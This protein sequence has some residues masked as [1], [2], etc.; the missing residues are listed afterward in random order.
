LEK[1]SPKMTVSGFELQ[2]TL[3]GN[4][5]TIRPLRPD[6]LEALFAVASDPLIWEQ[7]PAKTRCQRPGFEE[8]FRKGLE[9]G[10]AFLF[11]EAGTGEVI[12]SSRYCNLAPE[13]SEVEIGF[14]FLARRCWGGSFNREIKRLMIDH[15]FRFVD[16]VVFL[17]G[18]ENRRSRI[19]I[20]RIGAKLETATGLT[21][22]AS[23]GPHV[24]YRLRK[25]EQPWAQPDADR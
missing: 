10:G 24:R 12:G 11:R 19:A 2:P 7:H 14:T 6:D 16:S 22:S 20:E 25:G 18:E 1:W 17:V 13:K 5:V 23:P 4:L 9:S 21:Y 8:F 3:V 15:A